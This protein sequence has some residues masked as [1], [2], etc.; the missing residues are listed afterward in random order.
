MQIDKT[1]LKGQEEFIHIYE[2]IFA[3]HFEFRHPNFNKKIGTIHSFLLF[4]TSI[5]MLQK[6]V[7]IFC[8]WR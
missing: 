5:V 8:W 7:P 3:T 6:I 1:M 4:F 2:T